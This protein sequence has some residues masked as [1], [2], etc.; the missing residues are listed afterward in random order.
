MPAV[1]ITHS[2]GKDELLPSLGSSQSIMQQISSHRQ[3][4]EGFLQN[5]AN[6]EPIA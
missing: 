4:L 5:V 6:S 1:N 2:F 3:A